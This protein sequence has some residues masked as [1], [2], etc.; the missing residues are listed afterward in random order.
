[1]PAI[2]ETETEVTSARAAKQEYIS[3]LNFGDGQ[4]SLIGE[5]VYRDMVKLFGYA[6]ANAN[7][8]AHFV[9]RE[10]GA[11]LAN[12]QFKLADVK[13]GKVNKDGK[14]TVKFAAQKAATTHGDALAILELIQWLNPSDKL[15]I[16]QSSIR[17]ALM[18]SMTARLD[19]HSKP[20]GS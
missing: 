20:C 8:I 9:M 17:V 13:A 4:F 15:G 14:V 12:T 10:V 18:P 16:D 6:P 3:Y 1:M 11:L 2:I 19:K 5:T 7:G